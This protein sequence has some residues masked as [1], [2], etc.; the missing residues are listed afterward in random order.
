M[1][2]YGALLLGLFT[3]GGC[4]DM[5]TTPTTQVDPAKD[6]TAVNKRDSD[7][8]TK[9]PIDQN[10]SSADVKTTAEIRKK[11]V[12]ES[13]FSTNAQNVK[14]ITENGVVTLRGPVASEEERASIEKMAKDVAGTSN[15]ENQLEITP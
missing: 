9:T 13:T 7:D 12:A 3:L 2:I 5:T 6:N 11:V 10:E 1:R 15:V 4:G 14:I 8:S